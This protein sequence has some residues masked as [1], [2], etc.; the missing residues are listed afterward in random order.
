MNPLAR[1][2]GLTYVEVL[3]AAV[4]IAVA[5]VPAT[6]ALRTGMLSAEVHSSAVEQHYA[7]LARI[8]EV[9]AEPYSILTSAASVAGDYKTPTS[10]SDTGGTPGRVVVYIA[11]Y[12]AND[13]DGDGNVHTVPD[14]NVDGDNNPYT[15][16]SGPLWVRAEV[17]GSVVGLETLTAP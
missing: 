12:D 11:L 5:L 16:Y 17:E 14:P 15:D 13:A 6:Q 4:L 8:E 10:Y 9:L 3:I 2:S 1:Q 7:V